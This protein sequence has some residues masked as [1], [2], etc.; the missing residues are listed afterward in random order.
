M[1]AIWGTVLVALARVLAPA[2]LNDTDCG[3]ELVDGDI[4]LPFE[5]C[6]AW[7]GPLGGRNADRQ[8]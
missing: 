7:H 8:Y 5:R 2:S 6:T 4:V 3:D 1:L